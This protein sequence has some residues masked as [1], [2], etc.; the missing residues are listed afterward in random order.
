MDELIKKIQDILRGK[1]IGSILRTAGLV[2][3]IIFDALLLISLF[4]TGNTVWFGVFFLITLLIIA[5]ELYGMQVG[6]KMEDGTTKKMTISTNYK[7]YIERVGIVGYAPLVF[8]LT[9]II[10]LVLH[11]AVW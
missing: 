7:L 4:L 2:V 9:A 11:L 1:P 10:S 6:F 8:F 3:L 5:A